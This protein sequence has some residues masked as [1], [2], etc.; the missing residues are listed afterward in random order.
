M[1]SIGTRRDYLL[2]VLR[3]RLG[4]AVLV[5]N[6]RE[7]EWQAVF[8]G[9]ENGLPYQSGDM[10]AP[11]TTAGRSALSVC[12]AQ[13]RTSR[14]PCAKGGRDG[15]SHLQPVITRHTQVARVNLDRMRAN[16]IE[17]AEQCG[18]LQVPRG[19]GLDLEAAAS[20]DRLLIFCDEN[21]EV[22]DP[23]RA[24]AAAGFAT[25]THWLHSDRARGRLCRRGTSRCSNAR[26]WFRS[27]LA[28]A[29]CARTQP[30]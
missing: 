26:M 21:A 20:A 27:R 9:P 29:F 1:P 7:G 15:R 18:V 24:L 2:N 19:A 25:V 28:R 16:A 3:L 23:V 22:A 5:F 6:G 8:R 17:A 14:L 12:P 10:S 4:D 30:R 13:A 11:A